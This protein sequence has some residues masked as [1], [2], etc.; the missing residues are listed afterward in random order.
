MPRGPEAV[1]WHCRCLKGGEAGLAGRAGE[2]ARWGAVK[3]RM[4]TTRGWGWG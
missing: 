4:K 2:D 3:G 1:L